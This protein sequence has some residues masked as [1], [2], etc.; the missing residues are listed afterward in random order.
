MRNVVFILPAAVAR[1]KVGM[2]SVAYNMDCICP[3][4]WRVKKIIRSDAGRA[5][6][7]GIMTGDP[8][9]HPADP[10]K[11]FAINLPCFLPVHHLLRRLPQKAK[12]A[13]VGP[14]R[15]PSC[16]GEGESPA[17]SKGEFEEVLLKR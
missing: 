12:K 11:L 4:P 17:D 7:A 3:P 5:G 9:H 8:C 14:E 6:A 13:G 15:L 1:Q 10:F 2:S 16:G